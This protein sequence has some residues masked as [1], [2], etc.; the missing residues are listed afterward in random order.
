MSD[1][2]L[3]ILGVT[4]IVFIALVVT[5]SASYITGFSDGYHSCNQEINHDKKD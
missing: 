5:Q 2:I 4:A 3:K 1:K